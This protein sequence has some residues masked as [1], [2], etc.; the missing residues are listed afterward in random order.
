MARQSVKP[1]KD[2]VRGL[3][4][5]AEEEIREIA[6]VLGKQPGEITHK[7]LLAGWEKLEAKSN[8]KAHPLRYLVL[9]SDLPDTVLDSLRKVR[10]T[11]LGK[12]KER[13][14]AEIMAWH[15][16]RVARLRRPK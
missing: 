10:P 3:Y 4:L 11:A 13:L 15:N 12:L 16:D 14:R 5:Q 7:D 6:K 1:R 8:F 2:N 9:E